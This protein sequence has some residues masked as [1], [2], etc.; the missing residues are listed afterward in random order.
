MNIYLR[1]LLLGI[2]LIPWIDVSEQP[3]MAS[4][5]QKSTCKVSH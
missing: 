4:V 1:N 3:T 5:S 2:G